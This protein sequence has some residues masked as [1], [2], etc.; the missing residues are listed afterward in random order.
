MGAGA[1][2]GGNAIGKAQT[3]GHLADAVA[4]KAG[5][6]VFSPSNISAI[7]PPLFTPTPG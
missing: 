6:V 3:A 5:E 4:I 7:I 2:A 1:G